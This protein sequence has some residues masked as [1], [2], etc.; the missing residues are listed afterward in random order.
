[1]FPGCSA[2]R[3]VI[4]RQRRCGASWDR[5][6]VKILIVHEVN[7]LS[8]IIY[9]YQILPEIFSLLGHEITVVDFNDSWSSEPNGRKIQLETTVHSN[10]HRAYADA[11]ITVRRPGMVRIPLVSRVSGAITATLEVVRTLREMQPDVL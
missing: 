3:R 2:F 4:R 6:R 5:N 10:V 9:E 1:M 7:Y 8:K 11:S